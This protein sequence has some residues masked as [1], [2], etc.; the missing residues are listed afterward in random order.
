[1]KL[2]TILAGAALALAT[3]IA[4]AA[5]A[6]ELVVNGG[7][8]TGDFSGWSSGGGNYVN[9]A[10]SCYSGACAHSGAFGVSFGAV[11]GESP[12]SQVIA[13]HAGDAY[14]ISF[15][16][17]SIGS[18]GDSVSL[19]WDGNLLFSQSNIPAEG[20]VQHTFTATAS[21]DSTVLSLGLRNDPSWDGLDDISV[22]DASGGVP[23]PATWAMMLTG[24]VGAGAALRGRRRMALAA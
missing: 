19:S 8:E 13:T 4:G 10:D 17:N 7:F 22:T 16:L 9:P 11:G 6:Q 18:M 2:H 12:L 15:W 21:T 23:E 24:F 1:M 5:S 14:T 20:W 3:S